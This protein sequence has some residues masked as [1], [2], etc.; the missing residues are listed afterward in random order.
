MYQYIAVYPNQRARAY[1]IF[2]FTKKFE[3]S[4]IKC[5]NRVFF[6]Q[7]TYIS[8]LRD[9]FSN[10]CQMR[11][12]LS[13]KV[14]SKC[15]LKKWGSNEN[16]TQGSFCS[17]YVKYDSIE[18]DASKAKKAFAMLLQSVLSLFEYT[19]RLQGT[20]EVHQKCANFHTMGLHSILCQQKMRKICF[21]SMPV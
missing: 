7:R 12:T 20:L 3:D 11:D 9:L 2:S 8:C 18:R 13:A 4:S 21:Y 14:A 5:V 16:R 1:S 6:S 10:A 15:N 17:T 19:D